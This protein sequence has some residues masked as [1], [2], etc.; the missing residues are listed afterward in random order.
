MHLPKDDRRIAIWAA[1]RSVS[2][3]FEKTFTSLPGVR[4][5]PEPFTNCYYFGPSR[6]S[7]RY[8][9]VQRVASGDGVKAM[10]SIEARTGKTVIFKDLAF[11]AI[12]YVTDD[13]LASVTN[14]FIVRHP[15]LVI[16]S[17]KRLKPD[18]TE[19]ELG[20][21]PLG[22]MFDRVAALGQCQIIIKGEG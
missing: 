21:V 12:N 13:F 2:T 19:E 5:V 11:Q 6:R 8:G 20:F 15:D 9:S 17:L 14:T 3:A 7:Y 1:P 16:G 18:F 22:E 4:V 10:K